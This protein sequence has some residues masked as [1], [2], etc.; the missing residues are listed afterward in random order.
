VL[1]F[2]QFWITSC[3]FSLTNLKSSAAL[4]WGPAVEAMLAAAEGAAAGSAATTAARNGDER[5]PNA[6]GHA[7]RADRGQMALPAISDR[8]SIIRF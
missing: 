3:K 5:E 6:V 4:K 2:L 1:R 7:S 8:C